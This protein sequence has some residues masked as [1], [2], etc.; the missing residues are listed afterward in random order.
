[1]SVREEE[2][3]K[4]QHKEEGESTQNS[5][6]APPDRVPVSPRWRST[7]RMRTRPPLGP[8][9][10]SSLLQRYVSIFS[11]ELLEFTWL[12]HSVWS[13]T[14]TYILHCRYQHTSEKQSKEEQEDQL[15]VWFS[16]RE[17]YKEYE[18]LQHINY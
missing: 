6:L 12:H 9:R 15:H 7:I 8:L 11:L 13:Q 14:N 1:M 10:C 17:V 16:K 5:S 2:P 4:E 18:G 3:C